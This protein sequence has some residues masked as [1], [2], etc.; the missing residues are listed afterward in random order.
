MPRLCAAE[1]TF[2]LNN[3]VGNK[4][5]GGKVGREFKYF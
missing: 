3:K 2:N 5:G 4:A 1:S